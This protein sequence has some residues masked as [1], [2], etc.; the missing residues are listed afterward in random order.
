MNSCF[1]RTMVE[2]MVFNSRLSV[3]LCDLIFEYLPTCPH[4]PAQFQACRPLPLKYWRSSSPGH[5]E[6]DHKN[7][8]AY[9]FGYFLYKTMVT[10]HY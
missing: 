6:M 10:Q 3:T 1:I 8:L 4:S 9:S 5:L 2:V 7:N